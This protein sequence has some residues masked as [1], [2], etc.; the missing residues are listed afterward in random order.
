MHTCTQQRGKGGGLEPLSPHIWMRP[1]FHHTPYDWSYLKLLSKN[2]SLKKYKISSFIGENNN[3]W[4][5]VQTITPPA[6]ADRTTDRV[7]CVAMVPGVIKPE[8]DGGFLEITLLW[9]SPLCSSF[10]HPQ[11]MHLKYCGIYLSFYFTLS[12]ELLFK[13]ESNP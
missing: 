9:L 3:R 1:W 4:S 6:V 2:S 10:L 8:R 5:F 12:C 7:G 11:A 13:G